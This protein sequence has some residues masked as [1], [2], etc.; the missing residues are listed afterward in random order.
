MTS[1]TP[2]ELAKIIYRREGYMCAVCGNTYRLCIHHIIPRSRGGKN[3]EHN[4]IALCFDCHRA[5]HGELGTNQEEDT[6]QAIAEYMSDYYVE[7]LGV[8]WNPRLKPGQEPVKLDIQA[9]R[10]YP[11]PPENEWPPVIEPEWPDDI[12]LPY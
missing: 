6:Q 11:E 1:G 9:L 2:K 5:V 12:E 3:H 7:V 8:L 10:E 4:L